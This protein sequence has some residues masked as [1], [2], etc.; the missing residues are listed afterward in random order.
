MVSFL[1]ENTTMET[2]EKRQ[3]CRNYL[4]RA[5]ADMARQATGVGIILDLFCWVSRSSVKDFEGMDGDFINIL[6]DKLFNYSNL[7]AAGKGY[8]NFCFVDDECYTAPHPNEQNTSEKVLLLAT[9]VIEKPLFVQFGTELS[10][11]ELSDFK[12]Q[13]LQEAKATGKDGV[14]FLTQ[15]P[16]S[17]GARFFDSVEV[18]D[19][20]KSMQSFKLAEPYL[21]ATEDYLSLAELHLVR[22]NMSTELKPEPRI[23]KPETKVEIISYEK[24]TKE[25]WVRVLLTE[26]AE[27]DHVTMQ[28]KLDCIAKIVHNTPVWSKKTTLGDYCFE[29][30]FFQNPPSEEYQKFVQV[31][32]DKGRDYPT[33]L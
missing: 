8:Q 20:K 17:K 21:K 12:R 3:W 25:E 33:G 31:F 23:E 19:L 9:L 15:V 26:Y 13:K 14:F 7:T 30:L 10:A 24:R 1:L 28:W 22:L 5:I 32:K 29:E 11:T 27:M 4:I 6:G 18:V 16:Y 2:M